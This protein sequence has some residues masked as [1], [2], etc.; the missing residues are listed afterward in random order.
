MVSTDEATV[1]YHDIIDNMQVGRA[2]L[3]S[4][5]GVIP[6]IGWQLDTFGHSAANTALFAQMG[7]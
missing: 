3:K 5:F 2:W 7:I 1:T 4:E 6:T